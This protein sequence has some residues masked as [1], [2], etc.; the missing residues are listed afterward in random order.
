MIAPEPARSL[1]SADQERRAA[2]PNDAADAALFDVDAPPESREEKLSLAR[3]LL[4]TTRMSQR[5]IARRVGLSKDAVNRLTGPAVETHCAPHGRPTRHARWRR[6][7]GDA[8]DQSVRW[9]DPTHEEDVTAIA[10]AATVLA[11]GACSSTDGDKAD[12]AATSTASAPATA[13]ATSSA[14]PLQPQ[15]EHRIRDA[16]PLRAVHPCGP[17]RTEGQGADTRECADDR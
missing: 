10:A 12:S 13:D 8:T 2:T 15:R 5:E 9:H 14:P 3:N 17:E 4:A 1:D 6:S 7:V 11:L 16:R